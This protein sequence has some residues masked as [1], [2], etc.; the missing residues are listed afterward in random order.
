[1]ADLAYGHG[2]RPP[3]ADGVPL[4]DADLLKDIDYAELLLTL[5]D[6]AVR[7]DSGLDGLLFLY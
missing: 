3:S 6:Q 5:A 2:I 7:H 4:H 1:M